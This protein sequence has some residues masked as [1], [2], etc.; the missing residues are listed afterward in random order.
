MNIIIQ[1]YIIICVFLLIFDICFLILKNRRTD[2]FFPENKK[3]EKQ[4]LQQIKTLK[5]TGI[6][7]YTFEKE[8]QET[9]NM[10]T[11]MNVLEK[12]PEEKN[13]F[14]NS[15]CANLEVYQKKSNYEQAYYTYVIST[16][17]YQTQKVN[18]YFASRFISFLESE[19]LYTFINTMEA[20]YAFGEEGYLLQAL[21]KVDQRGTF[22][23]QKL[24]VDGLLSAKVDFKKLNDKIVENF[25]TYSEYMQEAFLD[26]FRMN[27][28]DCQ[29]LCVQIIEQK[30]C[31]AELRYSAMRYFKKFPNEKIKQYCINL[32]ENSTQFEWVDQMLAIQILSQY[33]EERIRNCMKAKIHSPSWYVRLNAAQYLHKY[34]LNFDEI[35]EIV[36]KKDKFA[37]EILLY[38]YSE[39]K[40]V[41][42][43]ILEVENV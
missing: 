11:L 7:D 42:Q 12:Y 26:Y 24:L 3:F 9:Q 2:V 35:E 38:Q 4:I 15:I 30:D 14:R 20:F 5:T 8:I 6:I 13:Y 17:D 41:S 22:Y 28:Y 27:N 34:Q 23:N 33:D 36:A 16:F 29:E 37:T 32:L 21:D 19:S 18:S 43:F 31:D 25:D 40:E 10:I 1:I 39:N